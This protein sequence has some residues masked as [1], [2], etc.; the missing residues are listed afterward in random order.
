MAVGD[1]AEVEGLIELAQGVM[2][3]S[4]NGSSDPDPGVPRR[5]GP[6]AGLCSSGP[7]AMQ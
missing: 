2:A 1:P 4:A 7:S 5:R 6:T 3:L